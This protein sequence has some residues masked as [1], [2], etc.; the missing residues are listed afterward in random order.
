MY[1]AIATTDLAA[2]DVIIMDG[3]R[4][5]VK[6]VGESYSGGTANTKVTL[7]ESYAGGMI[8]EECA[9][10]V[11]SSALTSITVNT[12]TTTR[13]V[14]R[15]AGDN[16]MLQGYANI[17]LV[18]SAL[19]SLNGP[20]ADKTLLMSA[21][22]KTGYP[23]DM[24]K[25]SGQAL[26]LYKVLNGMGYKPYKVTESV[27]GATYQYV[28][29]CSNRGTCDNSRGICACYKGYSG[30]NCDTQNMQAA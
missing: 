13:T 8:M 12:W 19:T 5:K 4:Y 22:G 20:D 29:Q 27:Q 7:S 9:D 17:N 28:S 11:T 1:K 3:R 6:A 18:F 14:S 24:Y 2:G 21:G 23:L 25:F 26:S 16:F 30:D 10:C 15:N